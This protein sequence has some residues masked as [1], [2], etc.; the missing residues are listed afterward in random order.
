MEGF[1]S[2]AVK[3]RGLPS[4]FQ[5]L[6]LPP[7]LQLS[8]CKIVLSALGKEQGPP[9]PAR[10][11][12]GLLPC[13]RCHSLSAEAQGPP[14]PG[15][16]GPLPVDVSGRRERT[17]RATPSLA[18]AFI[19]TSPP[20]WG[21]IPITIQTLTRL[22]DLAGPRE[23]KRLARSDSAL[24][25]QSRAPTASEGLPEAGQGTHTRRGRTAPSAGVGEG[26]SPNSSKR[27]STK[28]GPE[29]RSAVFTYRQET[30]L[31]VRRGV[32][33]PAVR[34]EGDLSPLRRARSPPPATGT[35][36]HRDAAPRTAYAGTLREF[37]GS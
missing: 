18:F 22:S 32:S 33:T 28:L 12:L 17:E 26:R 23:A 19:P 21:M 29:W 13:P 30:S 35:R 11:P 36:T 9:R 6:R 3:A 8:P 31:A 16:R 24:Q 27:D 14:I 2:W 20:I 34:R 4:V 15:A 10:C 1:K 25:R 37:P 7:D 5:S